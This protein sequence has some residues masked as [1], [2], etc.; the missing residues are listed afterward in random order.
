MRLSHES[1]V[2][3]ESLRSWRGVKLILLSWLAMLGF[4]FFLHGGLLAGFY[5]NPSSFL[6]TPLESFRRIPIGYLSFLLVAG[7]LVWIFLRLGVRGWWGGLKVA[8]GIGGALWFSLALGLYSISTADPTLLVAWGVGQTLEIAY[9]GAI[10]AYGME[11]QSLKKPFVIVLVTT[12]G[13]AVLTLV[14]QSLGLAPTVQA[15]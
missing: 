7:L 6:L 8:A 13:L 4:D 11:M 5:A 3:P 1:I 14:M 10:L 12:I 2:E 9:A 15:G